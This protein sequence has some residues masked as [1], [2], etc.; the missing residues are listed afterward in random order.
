MEFYIDFL[1]RVLKQTS[2]KTVKIEA[3]NSWNFP[4]IYLNIID[5]HFWTSFLVGM[6][7]DTFSQN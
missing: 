6:N 1:L 4:N 2:Y 5:S 7:P 3:I